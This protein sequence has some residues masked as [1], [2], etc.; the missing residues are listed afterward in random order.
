MANAK[1]NSMDPKGPAPKSSEPSGDTQGGDLQSQLE[2]ANARI[3]ELEAKSAQQEENLTQLRKNAT[4]VT[5]VVR[6]V[7]ENVNGKFKIID[8]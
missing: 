8:Y 1:P 5:G 7:R 4:V 6:E 3:Q 2:A